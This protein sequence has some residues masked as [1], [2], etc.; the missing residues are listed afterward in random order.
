MSSEVNNTETRTEP[1]LRKAHDSEIRALISLLDDDSTFVLEKVTSRLRELGH[2]EADRI[3]RAALDADI[4]ARHRAGSVLAQ[5]ERDAAVDE[6]RAMVNTNGFDLERV[7]TLLARTEYA[8]VNEAWIVSELNTWATKVREA[9]EDTEDA[10]EETRAARFAETLYGDGGFVGNLD[11]YYDTD[12]SYINRVL[13]A[14]RGIPISLAA[15]GLLVAERLG[16]P[17]DGIG[18]PT[19]FLLGWRTEHGHIL[20]DTF[21]GGKIIEPEACQQRLE[22]LGVVWRDSYMEP[23]SDQQVALRMVANLFLIYQQKNDQEHVDTL[24]RMAAA[25]QGK[26]TPGELN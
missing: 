22:Q 9:L 12:N 13:E 16:L 24:G 2:T 26:T 11:A 1:T 10:D 3:R 20:I 4:K 15:V 21:N 5:I 6:V 17:V 14:R 25:L 7:A 23:V 19:H 18:M 8:D